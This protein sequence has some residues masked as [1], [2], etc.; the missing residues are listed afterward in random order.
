MTT[1]LKQHGTPRSPRSTSVGFCLLV[2]VLGWCAGCGTQ[3]SFSDENDKLRAE[4]LELKQAIDTLQQ[5]LALREDELRAMRE[6]MDSGAAPSGDAEPPRLAGIALGAYTG[7]IDLDGDGRLD[8]LRVYVR[9]LDQDGRQ[10][11]AE[12]KARVRLIFVPDNADPQTALDRAYDAKQFHDAYRD[13]VTGTHYTLAADL[14]AEPPTT[15]TLRV[16]FT[17]AATGRSYFAQKQV[18]LVRDTTR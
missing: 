6:Q 10:I 15:A 9:P 16:D 17:D 4:R 11:T 12:G 7:P 2:C 1:D 14:P 8:A 13:G 3:R 18:T 5:R